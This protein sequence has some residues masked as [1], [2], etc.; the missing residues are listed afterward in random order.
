MRSRQ[1]GA[2]GAAHVDQCPILA[3]RGGACGT[4]Q[5]DVLAQAR[6][7]RY[8]RGNVRRPGNGVGV[9]VGRGTRWITAQGLTRVLVEIVPRCGHR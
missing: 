8:V 6:R 9:C 7:S 2:A 4:Q 5:I 1:V 3:R